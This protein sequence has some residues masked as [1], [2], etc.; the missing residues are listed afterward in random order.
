MIT[1]RAI[2]VTAATNTK[3]YDGTTSAAAVPTI[4][5]GSLASGDTATWSETYATK[6]VGTGKTLTPAGSVTDGNSG[7]NYSVSFVT[8]TTGV[9]SVRAITVTAAADSKV[10][11]GGTTAA[12]IPTITSGSLASGDTAS[13]T[14]TYAN[15][16]VGTGKT[17]TPAGS[18]ADGNSGNNYTVTFATISGGV[19]TRAG[20]DIYAVSDSKTYDGTTTSSGAPTVGGLQTGD[21]VSGKAQTFDTKNVGTSKTLSVS[22]YTVN[23]G[24]SG[25]NYTVTTHSVNTGVIDPAGLTV[26][27]RDA[28]KTYGQTLTFAGTEF[29]TSGLISGDSVT[30]VTLASDGAAA[31]ADHGT[32]DIAASGAS[33]TG[34][35]NYI[36]DYETGTLT[37][38]KAGLTVDGVTVEPKTYDGSPDADLNCGDATVNGV[39]NNDD[40]TLDTS[41]AAGAFDNANAGTDKA[42][43][44]TGLTVTGAGTGN[45]TLTP[46]RLD[47]QHHAGAADDHGRR[48]LQ[49]LGR[50][51]RPRNLRDVLRGLRPGG[52][53]IHR[54]GHADLPRSR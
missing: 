54:V 7:N 33:G 5:A 43:T 38:A 15:K 45:Y 52:Q 31:T 26:T 48:P 51:A 46:A 30:S 8:N 50:V 42:V 10:Y 36:I 23:D 19:I 27:A 16:N 1:A 6:D 4:T 32:Y 24:N 9:I 12:A 25:G 37:V 17:L 3:G 49:E 14:E 11:D 41:G 28:S 39:V 22:A 34:V 44:V 20:L 40:V 13:W 18:V 53:R 29:D 2:T 21:T 47:R 35:G